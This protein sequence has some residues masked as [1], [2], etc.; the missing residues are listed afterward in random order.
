MMAVIR[1]SR[2]LSAFVWSVI[3]LYRESWDSG[4]TMLLFGRPVRP[5]G[6]IYQ[7]NFSGLIDCWRLALMDSCTGCTQRAWH[8]VT[9]PPCSVYI[10]TPLTASS[11]E[12]QHSTGSISLTDP[13]AFNQL[14]HGALQMGLSVGWDCCGLCGKEEEEGGGELELVIVHI[15]VPLL[16]PTPPI[17][18]CITVLR[19]LCWTA[20]F[21]KDFAALSSCNS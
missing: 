12:P 14:G 19:D 1:S 13:T 10:Y 17:L 21:L 2:S 4:A 3:G 6:G 18:H 16:S 5:K 8:T 7:L 11:A 20:L 15:F 9:L